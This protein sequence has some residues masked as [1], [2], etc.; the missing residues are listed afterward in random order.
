MLSQFFINPWLAAGGVALVSIPIIIHLMNRLRYRTVRFAAMEFLLQSQEQNRRRLLFE[1]LLLLLL[2][3]LIVLAIVALFAR[4]LL[5]P[6]QLSLLEKNETHHLIVLDDSGSMRDR[7]GETTAYGEAL[8]TLKRLVS[9][10]AS[11]G[12]NHSVTLM[13]TSNPDRTAASFTSRRADTSLVGELEDQL[14]TMQ[15]NCG[16]GS[17]EWREVFPAVERQLTANKGAFQIVHVLSDFRQQ[18]WGASPTLKTDLETLTDERIRVHLVPTVPSL[19]G[20]LS[21]VNF[22]GSLHTAAVGVPVELTAEVSNGGD[23][24]VENVPV[25]V[26]VNG[27]PLP[28]SISIP[29]I[30]AG[31]SVNESFEVTLTSAGEHAISVQLPADALE[32]D[33]TRYVTI[34]VPERQRVLIADGSE[35]TREAEY[36]A[37]ALAADSSITGFEVVIVRPD[38]LRDLNLN[39]FTAL[40]LLNVDRLSPDI[41]RSVT[42]YVEA[43]GG[44]AWFMGDRVDA[45]FY[46][47]LSDESDEDEESEAS[48]DQAAL[49]ASSIFPLDIAASPIELPRADPTNPGADLQL[50]DRPL[51]EILNAEEGL[52]AYYLN[53]YRYVPLADGTVPQSVRV[54][55]RLRNQAPLFFETRFGRGRVFVSLTSAGPMSPVLEQ[56][57]HNWPFDINAPGFTVF[58][59]ELVKY[60]ASRQGASS[61]RLVGEDLL[62]EIDPAVAYPDVTFYPPEETG[63]SPVTMTATAEVENNGEAQQVSPENGTVQLLAQFDQTQ[64]PGIYRISKED[65]SRVAT[66]ELVAFNVPAEESELALSTPE[67]MRRELAGVD[68]I[69]VQDVGGL[70][71]LTQDDP[72][73]ELRMFLLA[74]LVALL[75]GE[76]WLAYRLGYHARNPSAKPAGLRSILRS[77]YGRGRDLGPRTQ[78][79]RSTTG[80]RS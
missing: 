65:L 11:H 40:Y 58:H 54:L 76:Q 3:I 75:I 27:E 50:A 36:V 78:T 47:G 10:L 55:G 62:V 31:D 17:A 1:Q 14:E 39:E 2:R 19:H 66:T 30:E 25:R 73:R 6:S 72:G 56:R 74:L 15:R 37:D 22:E 34:N 9:D 4:L 51:F 70:E 5:D 64:T 67:A 59:L 53:I 21:V 42:A 33:N 8:Q 13:Q 41:L 71:G 60:I 57:W 32:A 16:Y 68:G 49:M 18:E 26:L 12:G 7:W 29:S 77:R 69:V 20:N 52:L 38:A 79:G 35:Q 45:S 80:G 43:G 23:T 61:T 48:D 44:L 28:Q 46:N 24:V 63:R